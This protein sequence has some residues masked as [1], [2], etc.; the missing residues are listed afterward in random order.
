MKHT[1][2]LQP[3]QS[4]ALAWLKQHPKGWLAM[5]QGLGKTRVALESLDAPALCVVPAFLRLN[6]QHE[7][8]LWRPDL[9]VQIV[10]KQTSFARD[11]DLCILSYEAAATLVPPAHFK[12]LVLDEA[13]FAKN[14]KAERT[15]RC[16]N[17]AK[18]IPRVLLLDG[19]PMPNRPVELWPMAFAIGATRLMY[20]DWGFRYCAGRIGG[21]GGYDFRGASNMD[22]LREWWKQWSFRCTKEEV[23]G[24]PDKTRRLV[25]LD[26]DPSVRERAFD[27]G[28]IRRNPN[29]VAFVGLAEVLHKHGERKAGNAV[30]YIDS[31]LPDNGP[32]LVTA[33]HKTVIDNM[34]RDLAKL[35]WRTAKIT[36]ET[37]FDERE[38]IVAAFNSGKLD[39]LVGNTRAMGAGLTLTGG[40]Y[41]VS[42]EADWSYGQNVQVEDR[43]HRIGQT[44]PVQ[45]DYL[46]IDR[47]ID[48]EIV[49]SIM[50]KEGRVER[51]MDD[52]ARE[53]M[54]ELGI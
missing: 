29:P 47:S 6:W 39:V 49:K 25:L 53:S 33:R 14:H 30:A 54:A 46:V 34:T 22:E 38:K 48:Y 18:K 32:I 27:V 5:E 15:K 26:G 4:Q 3:Q 21:W 2:P 42:V 8:K 51:I 1:I 44:R 9:K 10:T 35:K 7:A 41:G 11:A 23:G 45:W 40:C 12:T 28:E 17:L 50:L 16:M 19:T 31:L 36:G 43:L 24:L 37:P 52:E 20:R 13:R